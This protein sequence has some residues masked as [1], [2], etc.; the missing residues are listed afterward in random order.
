MAPKAITESAKLWEKRYERRLAITDTIIVVFAVIVAQLLRFGVDRSSLEV[1]PAV[2]DNKGF[3]V[4]YT[5]I[6][7]ALIAAWLITLAMSGSRSPKVVGIGAT[8]YRNVISATFGVFGLLAIIAFALRS[9]VGRGYVLIALPLGLFLLL[10]GR[11][12]WRKYLHHQRERHHHIYRTLIVGDRAKSA[13]VAEE[14]A[15]TSYAGFDVV[16]AVT[17]HGTNQE[18]APGVPVLSG[19]EGL[20]HVVDA[21]H[22]DTLILTSADALTPEHLRE[23]G[24]QLENRDVDIIAS[25]GLTGIAGARIHSRP[26]SGMPLVHLEVPEFEGGKYY[27]KRVFDIVGSALALILISPLALVITTLIRLDSPGPVIFKQERV[28][29]GGKPFT[30]YKFRSM[31]ADAELRRDE[32]MNDE[33]R[34]GHLFKHKSDPRIT[35][36]GKVL[37]KFSLDELPQFY[38]VLRGDMSIVG[39]RPPLQSEVENYE[40]W[41]HRRLL[42]K[43][44]ITGLW[45]VSGRSDLSWED[46]IR[47]DLYYVENWSLIEDLLIVLRT[48]RTM[49]SPKGAY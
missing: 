31:T 20:M 28:G 38:N 24:W 18:L 27:T 12:L 30:M 45:Q 42:V 10:L 3:E 15:R 36:V 9:Q 11:W 21:Y 1:N 39:P 2:A 5:A 17:E 26:V 4:S 34:N 23:I 47:L 37:R 41:V 29:I 19:Y 43:P 8:E 44:G 40:A 33:T 6:S 49:I 32:L 14:I 16:G 7:V 13:T 22:I 35:R 25:I 48:V 46:S